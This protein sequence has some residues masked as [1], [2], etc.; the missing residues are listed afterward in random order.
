[1]KTRLVFASTLLSY[2]LS[3][4]A[5]CTS[6][7]VKG[8]N[9]VNN[10]T[11]V[12]HAAAPATHDCASAVAKYVDGPV[13]KVYLDGMA[14][15][16]S[17]YKAAPP[18]AEETEMYALVVSA[19]LPMWQRAVTIRCIEDS[20]SAASI[21]CYATTTAGDPDCGLTAAQKSALSNMPST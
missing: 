12:Q 21:E 18:T 14:I 5:G 10:S 16:R 4:A 20:W 17:K 8:V 6:K 15:E 11:D 19:K 7:G 13:R 1:M 2:L 9:D 3:T